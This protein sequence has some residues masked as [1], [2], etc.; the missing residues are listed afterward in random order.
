MKSLDLGKEKISKLLLNFSVPCIISMLV[1]ALYN[2][3]DQ[4]FIGNGV[5]YLGNAATNVVYPFTVIA[6]AL[7]LLIGDG[8]GALF[9]LYLGKKDKKSANKGVGNALVLMVV[10]SIIV[11]VLGF[12]FQEQ[13]LKIFGVTEGTYIYAKDYFKIILM[14]IPF[15]ILT[16]GLNGLI[17]ADGSPKF[18]MFAT[19]IGAIL[20]IIL[21]PIA[22]FVFDM[23]VKGA[24]L[25]TIVGQI[26]SC[27]VTLL[28]FRK[29]KKVQITKE[30]LKLDKNIC[31]KLCLLGISSFITQVSIVIVIAVAN[32]MIVKYGSLSKYGAD[33]PLSAVGIVMKVFAIVIA[34][35]IGTSIGGQPIIGYN[36]GAG[37]M[38]RV[39][40][41]FRLI[42]ITNLIIGV[43][44]FI[45]F[46]FFPQFIIN[47][48]GNESDLYNEYALLCFRIYLSGI[49]FTC[50][51]K[52]CSIYLQS[53]GK[54]VKSMIISLARDIVIFIPTLMILASVY[55]VVG[56]LWAALVADIISVIMAILL[57]KLDNRKSNK[58]QTMKE[59]ELPIERNL[60]SENFVIT[61]A[62]EYGS[63]G[64]YV[65]KLLAEEL[66]IPFYDKEIIRMTEEQSGLTEKF[67]LDN[68]QRKNDYNIYYN[69]DD[70]I[71]NTEAKVIKKIS[72]NPCV[73]IGRCAD[74]ILENQE[75]VYKVFLYSDLES[76]IN[77][78]V[79][80]YGLKKD[81]ALKNIKKID[82]DR[83]KHYEYYT[84]KKWRDF[85][86]YDIALNV[87][88]LGILGTVHTLKNIIKNK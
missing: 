25:A 5:G 87:D 36:Y 53:I 39:K 77:R 29:P 69:I 82:R 37:K 59:V 4:I 78:C 19:L 63:G 44:A 57:L 35:V 2:I 15:Y 6:L 21:D 27:I 14:G 31:K 7:A 86:N 67:I 46:Q 72:K 33:I 56:M 84:N 23:G 83:A 80:Y 73:I 51:T 28:Y 68:E 74:Y 10:V 49:I 45:I 16:S 75:N 48:F 9:S 12:L 38:D 24:A 81:E 1:G 60:I 17:R 34:L 11:T 79:K 42:L 40:K 62:R 88:K 26:I 55:G 30:T 47:I 50:I 70:E 54:S 32:N 18:A 20:N 65:G 64:R 13:L 22:I 76:K 3:V 43:V 58:K 66:N 61:I 71:F 85:E 41:T 8:A 52:C